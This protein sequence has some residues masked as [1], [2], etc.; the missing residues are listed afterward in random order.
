[1]LSN[2]PK[3]LNRGLC[4]LLLLI[5]MLM[6]M[7]APL[8]SFAAWGNKRL[9]PINSTQKID[10]VNINWWDN[11]SDPLLKQYIIQ[12]IQ[13]NHDAHK[14]SWQVEEYRQF[15][16]YQFGQEL[17]SL[18]MGTNYI[19]LHIPDSVAKDFN[20]N[21]FTV[22]FIANYEADIFLK[23]KDKTKS[24]KK[25][26]ESSKYKEKGTYISLAADVATVYI[27]VVK[28]DE[29][30]SYQDEIIKTKKEILTR[31]ESRYKRGLTTA[32]AINNLKKDYESAKSTNNDY[33]KSR[34][35]ALTQL[36]LLIGDSPENI[37]EY[38]RAELKTINY[39][40]KIPTQISS[41]VIFSRP[42]IL[43]AEANLEQGKIDVRVARK[44]FLP[45]INITGLY[46]MSTL[47]GA[48]FFSWQSAVA[49]IMAGAT[50]DLFKGGMKVANLKINK[51][52][53]EQ[54]FETYKQTDLIAIKEVKDA[55]I[56][57]NQ[58]TKTDENAISKSKLQ[59]DNCNRACERAARGTITIQTLLS[60]KEQLLTMMQ[61]R[62]DTKTARLIDYIT[63]Y[64]AVGGKL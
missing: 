53:Y 13:N 44:D 60:E 38:K 43:A 3:K 20:K 1:M 14:A 63:L 48:N 33:I 7:L 30:I 34:E 50:Q 6:S 25:A 23:N 5:S 22:P 52:R 61:N 41:D 9:P 4:T 15:V 47:G 59:A 10:Y 35:K 56:L 55:L 17:P 21:I 18:S 27:N 29:L 42:D 45:S 19:G 51:S 31:E 24:K 39:K 49:A 36:A 8:P 40:S 46:A 2:K 26:Y 16:K 54:L 11:F 32:S 57:I 62:V 37:K 58:D 28:F 12:A 64:K